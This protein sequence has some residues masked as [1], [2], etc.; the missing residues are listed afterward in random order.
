M[1]TSI[2]GLKV[3]N[4]EFVYTPICLVSVSPMQAS[5]KS[6]LAGF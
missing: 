3:S 5:A 2:P 6:T 1:G 4:L